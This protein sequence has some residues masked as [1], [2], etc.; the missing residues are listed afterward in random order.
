PA[1]RTGAPPV[2]RYD[3]AHDLGALFHDVQVSG[4]FADSKTFVDA[5]PL[6]PPSEIAAGYATAR[7]SAGFN[8]RAFVERHFELPRPIAAG[9]H[10]DPSQT[11]EQHIRRSEEHTSELQSR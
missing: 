4:I 2:V 6:E 7:T 5:R 8:L 3:P 9:F 1:G 10:T 11:M